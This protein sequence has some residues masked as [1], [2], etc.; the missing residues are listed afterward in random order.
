MGP[1][2]K[3]SDE[4]RVM[5]DQLENKKDS[6]NSSLIT[7][8]SSRSWGSSLVTVSSRYL[9]LLFKFAV[10][11]TLFYMLTSRVGGIG[12]LIE[13][14]RLLNPLAFCAAIVLY[15]FAAYVSTLRW[16][17]LIP[18]RISTG[19]LFSMYM[20]GSFFNTYLPGI[21]GG[22]A[23]KA[24][25]MSRELKGQAGAQ[26]LPLQAEPP[27]RTSRLS[28][29]HNVL[30]IASVFMDRYIGFIA[31]LTIG[32]VAFP[33][34]L[35][36]LEG[37]SGT[38]PVI[39][40][41]PGFFIVFAAV[42]I[43]LKFR[44]G[45]NIKFLDRIYGYFELYKA[46]RGALVL[47][48]L[49]SLGVQAMGIA[50]V[51]VLSVGLALDISFYSLLI[52]IPIIILIS[53]I[54][55]SISGIGLREGAFVILLGAVGVPARMAMTLSITWFLSVFVAGIWGLIEYLRFKAVLGG[56]EK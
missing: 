37:A 42:S 56:K 48:F 49:Y 25:Y 1:A 19:R 21:V 47:A 44:L 18:R 2:N 28:S 27:T 51:Y 38:W 22:D 32:A 10:S 5:G 34:G 20:I 39:W 9:L 50:A 8:H 12:A 3:D 30:A 41:L 40:V 35:T 46:K 26:A 6:E 23:V 55:V 52:F 33:F 54:P 4:L 15:L 7:H 45:K 43:A 11:G 53:F 31:L 13:K 24:Y 14:M 16:Q 17:L 36:Y 29:E